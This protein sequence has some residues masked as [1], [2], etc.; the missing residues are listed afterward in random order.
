M[1]HSA[2]KHS[3]QLLER[4][5]RVTLPYLL[6][7]P[8]GYEE[9]SREWPLLLFLHGSGEQGTELQLVMTHGPPE[10]VERGR[11][12]PFILVSPQCPPEQWW[13]FA[14]LDVLL[15]EIVDR[16][17]VDENRIYVTG[18][19]MGG[20]ATWTLATE[21]PGRFAAIAP[22]CG[23]G[24]PHRARLLSNMPI[25]AFHGAKDPVISLAYS[26]EMVNA[27]NAAGGNATLTIYPDAG[28]N[29]WTETYDNPELY[30][31]LLRQN[32]QSKGRAE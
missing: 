14:T 8:R 26:Q 22:I 6:Y 16:Y 7:L 19:S 1:M 9:E 11:E 31:W 30:E 13:S 28:H 29:S 25:W 15:D 24:I 32:L 2:G 23:G 17:A 20:F 4:D 3:T 10:Q 21:F 27:V 12:F 5:V 18:L